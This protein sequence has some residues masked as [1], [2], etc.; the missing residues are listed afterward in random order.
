MGFLGYLLTF[1]TRAKIVTVTEN[2]AKEN[3]MKDCVNSIV[4]FGMNQKELDIVCFVAFVTGIVLFG[5][6]MINYLN[7]PV[8]KEMD[9]SFLSVDLEREN[10]SR[11]K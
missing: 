3:E 4:A 10:A 6:W 9:R 5:R 11:R 8:G 1:G 2:Q 7:A